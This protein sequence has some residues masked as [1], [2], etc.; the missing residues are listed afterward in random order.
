MKRVSAPQARQA[1]L[2]AARIC[3][4]VSKRTHEAGMRALLAGRQ[5]VASHRGSDSTT[6]DEC[7]RLIRAWA[8]VKFPPK[9]KRRG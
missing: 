5:N 2:Q 6:A 3:E 8:D 4:G 1:L 7:A 9:R